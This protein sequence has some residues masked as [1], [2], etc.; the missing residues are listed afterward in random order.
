M[1]TKILLSII[2][3]VSTGLASGCGK[4]ETKEK[5]LRPVRAK[6]AEKRPAAGAVRY[7]ASIRPNSQV[8]IAFKVGGYVEG[9]AQAPDG[10]G[11]WRHIQAG[12]VVSKGT[13]L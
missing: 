8:E 5:P 4:A 6:A 7:S 3:L 1:K 10:V 9:V 13:V 12:D 11:G 2:V